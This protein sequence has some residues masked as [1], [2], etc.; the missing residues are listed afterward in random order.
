MATSGQSE[1]VRQTLQNQHRLEEE[2]Q[3]TPTKKGAG[4]PVKKL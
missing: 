3:T 4:G 1:A 2:K